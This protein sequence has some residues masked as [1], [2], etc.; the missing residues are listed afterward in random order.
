MILERL[1]QWFGQPVEEVQPVPLPTGP[2]HA[3]T[4][5]TAFDEDEDADPVL[6]DEQEWNP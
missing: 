2:R 1:K 6:F 5:E 4:L 3:D